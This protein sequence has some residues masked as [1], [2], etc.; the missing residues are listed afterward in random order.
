LPVR[1]NH[2]SDH[3]KYG[4]KHS[5]QRIPS[6]LV[7]MVCTRCAVYKRAHLI[8]G[9]FKSVHTFPQVIQGVCTL[10][11]RSFKEYTH[12]F[13]GLFGR[14]H[15]F[16]DAQVEMCAVLFGVCTL[17]SRL[18][19][20]AAVQKIR[21]R[22]QGTVSWLTEGGISHSHLKNVFINDWRSRAA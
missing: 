21:I 4:N 5:H 3:M 16:F 7:Y 9:P 8:L 13:S 17:F 12:Y 19:G 18:A 2:Y 15:I 11:Y 22:V 10:Y 6:A 20:L 14:V 1:V